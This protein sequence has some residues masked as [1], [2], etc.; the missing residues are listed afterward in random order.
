M[1]KSRALWRV[2]PY[3]LCAAV[4]CGSALAVSSVTL[5]GPN[6]GV[7]YATHCPDPQCEPSRAHLSTTG[8]TDPT[9][10]RAGAAD[11]GTLAAAAILVDDVDDNTGRTASSPG[12]RVTNMRELSFGTLAP[13]SMSIALGASSDRHE[14]P[15]GLATS[16]R[17]QLLEARM[18]WQAST[19]ALGLS[20]THHDIVSVWKSGPIS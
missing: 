10:V 6:N 3:A 18:A 9:G 2:M 1:L 20:P 4:A 14:W 5:T 19:R 17:S 11:T 13:V 8:N 12:S 7:P 15:N 16:G